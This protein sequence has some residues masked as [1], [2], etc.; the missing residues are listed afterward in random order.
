MTNHNKIGVFVGRFQPLHIGH[1]KIIDQMIDECGVEHVLILI[2][3]VNE[4]VSFR[5]PFSYSDR[6]TWLRKLYPS[7]TLCGL[8]DF[9][10][11][12]GSWFFMLESL[13]KLKFGDDSGLNSNSVFYGGCQHDVDWYYDVGL[14]VKLIDRCK[15]ISATFI[16]DKMM[17]KQ[18]IRAFV[19]DIL[20]DSILARFKQ[21]L[22]EADKRN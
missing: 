22:E 15:L 14:N 19:P 16:R 9:H 2:G 1:T 18:D 11:D 13:I 12:D 7:L 5:C 20:H 8:P 4:P 17:L 6:Y 21:I 10:N 3:S